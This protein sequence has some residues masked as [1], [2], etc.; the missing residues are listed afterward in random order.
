MSDGMDGKAVERGEREG[1]REGVERVRGREG[2]SG[3]SEREGGREGGR[4][5]LALCVKW[6]LEHGNPP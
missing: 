5:P 6:S 1:G 2:G 3:V 4:I